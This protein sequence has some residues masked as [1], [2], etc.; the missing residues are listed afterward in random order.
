MTQSV[1]GAK[2]TDVGINRGVNS[3]WI[4][5]TSGVT[6]TPPVPGADGY[7]GFDLSNALDLQLWRLA[8]AAQVQSLPVLVQ[9]TGSASPGSPWEAVSYLSYNAPQ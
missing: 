5:F 8:L 9:G 6:G 7:F 2:I 4:H 1:A 3:A